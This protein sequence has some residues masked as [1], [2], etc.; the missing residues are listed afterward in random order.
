MPLQR[1]A[2]RT[3]DLF[4]K[5]FGKAP[6]FIVA[7]PGRVNLM[8][9]HTD[10]NDG[11]VLPMAIENYTVIAGDRQN[12]RNA[13]VH[14][15]TTGE[16]AEFVVT[17]K[18]TPGEPAWSN[19]VRGVVSG[20]LQRGINIPGFNMLIES[21]LPMGGGLASSAAL[22][23]ATATMLETITRTKL[24]PIEKALLCQE[25]EH[26]FAR[27]PCGIMDQFASTLGVADRALL[28]DCRS[29]EATPVLMDDHSV[30]VLIINTNIRH[31]LA[32]SEYPT[33]RAQCEAAAKAI[34]VPALRDA[35]QANLNAVA[36]KLAQVVY[37]RARHVISEIQRTL[38]TASLIPQKAWTEVGKLMYDSHHSLRKDFEVSCPELDHV[39]EIA[40]TIGLK[41]GV[42]GCRMT[43]AGFGGCAVALVKT[44][45]VRLLTRLFEE[46]YELRTSGEASIFASRPANGARVLR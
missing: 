21:S 8:G 37:R 31:R 44:D 1:L 36:P 16:T 12:T 30:T 9:E 28:L 4:T 18:I 39:V 26:K 17:N 23:V 25:A 29:R 10:Y 24:P 7:A 15:I 2:E 11:F 6:R 14:S 22:E 32:Q 35:T 5:S 46:Q 43:G 34:G 20:F 41:G 19:Y 42:Y 40:K 27:V 13:V 33:R 45:Q 3:A 38:E